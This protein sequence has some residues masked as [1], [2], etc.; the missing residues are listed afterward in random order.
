M[1]TTDPR[2]AL[3]SLDGLREAGISFALLHGR[4]RLLRG[5]VSD[6]DIVV[7][8]DP[9]V[10]V[11]RTTASWR[12]RGMLPVVIWPYD[13]GGTATVFLTTPDASAGVQLDLLYDRDGV[14][15][16]AVKSP[17]L[18]TTADSSVDLPVVSDAASMV[19]QWHKGTVKR[20]AARLNALA[21]LAK[22]IDR[23]L[24]LSTCK[25]I[26]GSSDTA[27]QMLEG[28]PVFR[29]RRLDGHLGKRGARVV[30]RLVEPVGF[31]AHAPASAVGAELASRFSRFLV[32][33]TTQPTP[34]LL[35]QPVWW[36]AT[37]MPVR[38]RPGIFVST[39]TLPQWRTPDIV[40]APSSP[41][42]AAKRL[43]A[44]MTARFEPPG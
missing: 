7:G 11:R 30:R 41:R 5:D 32:C 12:S 23:G 37:V 33:A 13:I 42:E 28:R 3:A 38:L 19:Y 6:V 25:A 22:S 14:G 20:Q 40:L 36:A 21:E 15:R 31:W 8:E 2:L 17:P 43:T 16:Y 1:A 26:S 18:L 4:E 29:R 39:G 10:V 9:R 24:L 44:A 35:R 27:R 34:S